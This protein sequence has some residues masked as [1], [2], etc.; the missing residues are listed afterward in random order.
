M[1]R[2]NGLAT[3]MRRAVGSAVVIGTMATAA[4]AQ[5]LTL[6]GHRVHQMVTTEGTAGA[7][8]DEW[9]AARSMSLNWLTFNVQDVHERLYREASLSTTSSDVGFVANP[10]SGRSSPRCSRLST[11]SSLRT[12]SRPLTRCH[13]ACWMR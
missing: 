3:M 4:M 9:A 10:I 13:R 7:P 2:Q 1:K 6:I 12:R 8:A 5:E 11:T